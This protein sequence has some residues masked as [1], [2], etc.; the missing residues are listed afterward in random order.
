V[1]GEYGYA[2][3]I[4]KVN[5]SSRKI[6]S[7]PTIDYA[8]RFLGGRGIAAR[9]YWEEVAPEIKAFDPENRLMFVTGPLAGISPGVG[10]VRWLVCGKSPTAIPEQFSYANLG[11]S[12]GT[13]LKR[14]GFDGVIVHGKSDTPVYLSVKNG[15]AELKDAS[16]L[17][18]KST[19]ETIE[20]LKGQL[21][22]QTRVATIGPA[23]ENRVALATILADNDASGSGGFGAV[24][25]SKNL[26]AI[27]AKGSQKVTAAF[28]DRLAELNKEIRRLKK[29]SPA[30][31]VWGGGATLDKKRLDMCR[32][33]VLGCERLVYQDSKGR[34]GKFICGQVGFYQVR[35]QRYYGDNNWKEVPFH[36]AMLANDYGVD[37]FALGVMMMWLSRCYRAGIL[38]DESAGIPLSKMGSIEFM[39]ALVSKMSLRE[40]FGDVLADGT[41]RAAE[42]LGKE[43]DKLITDYASKGE[44]GTAY[45]PRYYITTGLLYAMEPRMPIQQLHEVSRLFLN[46]VL[47]VKKAKGAYVST[48][49]LRATAKRFWGTELAVDLSTYEGKALTA[50][51]IQDRRYVHES[52]ILCD[53]AWPILTVEFSDDHV[54]DPSLESKV[55]SAALGEEINEEELYKIGERVVNMQRAILAR[56]AR[57]S[58]TLPEFHF[59]MPMRTDPTNPE[60]IAPGKNGEIFT[61]KGEILDRAKFEEMKKEFY[62]LR[63]W[64][65]ATGL[66]TKARLEALDLKDM[67]NGLEQRGLVV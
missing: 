35:A 66:Q 21:G 10:G 43:S 65:K 47:W 41:V 58:D 67:A 48:D 29:S 50:T 27:A 18:G 61:K 19:A 24:M 28:P 9:V 40:G 34:E 53:W 16:M 20:V 55:L 11:G 63:G 62:G 4:L 26:K 42:K 15:K 25:G 36:A 8:T 6:S 33:C 3:N 64:D 54:G 30:A 39:E 46:W 51:R 14:A 44:Q 56:E 59:T 12:W 37:V 60:G 52:L 23:G 49:V 32:G 17:W 1:T 45:D 38:T 7:V 31:S 2:G 22:K 57:D 5:L 13:E